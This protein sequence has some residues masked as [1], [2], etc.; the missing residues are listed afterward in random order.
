MNGVDLIQ[1]AMARR[2]ANGLSVQVTIEGQAHVRHCVDMADRDA[3]IARCA[4]RGEAPVI[5]AAQ[6]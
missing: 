5:L 2:I 1:L 6:S 4:A 3:Y